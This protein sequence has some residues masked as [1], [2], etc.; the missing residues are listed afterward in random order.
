[1][2][3]DTKNRTSESMSLELQKLGSSINV[4]DR[5]DNITFSVQTLKKNLD[6]TLALLEERIF[7]PKFNED[8]FSRI[9]KQSL[10]AFKNA[11][12]QPA[13]VASDVSA[14]VNFGPNHILGIGQSGSEETVNNLSL[15]DIFA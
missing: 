5:T 3:E 1:M 4:S 6:A 14:K 10:E 2:N 15:K 7:S 12:T 9:K 11:K 13:S 8:D